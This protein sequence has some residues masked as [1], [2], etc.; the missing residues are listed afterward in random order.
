MRASDAAPGDA[1]NLDAEHA[2]IAAALAD[3]SALS[4]AVKSLAAD[5]VKK[6]ETR[7]A[8]IAAARNIAAV[9]LAALGKPATQ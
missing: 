3:I 7:Q 6:A 4:D 1:T 5:W 2:D 9:A 8:A